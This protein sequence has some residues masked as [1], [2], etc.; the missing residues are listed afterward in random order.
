MTD[1]RNYD[2]C[3]HSFRKSYS[4]NSL[5][6]HYYYHGYESLNDL[7]SDCVGANLD[8]YTYETDIAEQE[9]AETENE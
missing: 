8:Y 5:N 6:K 2:Y 1:N 7:F 3:S 9:E 4:G